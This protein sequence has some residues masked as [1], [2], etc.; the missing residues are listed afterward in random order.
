MLHDLEEYTAS[1]RMTAS[2]L[3]FGEW[4]MESFGHEVVRDRR[5]RERVMR[6]LAKGPAAVIVPIYPSAP[7]DESRP[8]YDNT[9]STFPVVRSADPPAVRE[10]TPAASPASTPALD[11]PVAEP[12]PIAPTRPLARGD[13]GVSLFR[14][15]VLAYAVVLAALAY[16]ALRI[17]LRA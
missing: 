5:A 12:T 6:A 7:R 17:L 15:R 3:R 8:E 14:P 2:Q 13:E 9:P 16:A 4:L 1:A 11:E 10:A